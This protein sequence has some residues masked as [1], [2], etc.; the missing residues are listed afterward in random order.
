[1]LIHEATLCDAMRDQAISRG[2]STPFMAAG[3]AQQVW[4]LL[5]ST[6]YVRLILQVLVR[7]FFLVIVSPYNV[8]PSAW[9]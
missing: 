3:F 8:V 2:H 6:I 5:A 1:M 7:E 9:R 4:A